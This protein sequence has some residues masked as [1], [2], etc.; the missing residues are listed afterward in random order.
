MADGRAVGCN[1]HAC[2]AYTTRS[3]RDA[4]AVE[5]LLAG[6]ALGQR[7]FVVTADE[8]AAAGL[9]EAVVSASD[10]ATVRGI[11]NV[12]IEDAYDLSGPIDAGAQLALYSGMVAQAIAD[13]F[14]GL[15]VFADITAL[16]ADP[17]RR[18]GH[19]RWEHIA[20]AWMAAGNPLA[21]LCAY[22]I[23]VL[24]EDPQP[25]MAVHPLRRGPQ[26]AVS[27][28]GL[29]WGSSGRVLAGEV[30]VFA[31]QTLTEVLATLPQGSIDLDVSELSYLSARGA[32][33]LARTADDSPGVRQ[34]RMVNAQPIVRRVWESLEFDP[35]LL[36][37]HAGG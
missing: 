18:A 37:A 34:L 24:G 33:A 3:E 8:D 25:V 9:L 29:Y 10:T 36:V 1:D 27:P 19:A 4:A 23:G 31:A 14:N 6:A 15:R 20:D 17:A 13:G 16:I 35:G 22:D 7:L 2:W 26:H 32:A 5:W 28:F 11:V 12:A 21:P 30:D